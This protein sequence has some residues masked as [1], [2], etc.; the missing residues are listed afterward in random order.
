MNDNDHT[1][2]RMAYLRSAVALRKAQGRPLGLWL[3]LQILTAFL[4][5]LGA[6][7]STLLA[8]LLLGCVLIVIALY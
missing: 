1:D 5:M 3:R 8:L 6:T 7:A 2:L 4:R